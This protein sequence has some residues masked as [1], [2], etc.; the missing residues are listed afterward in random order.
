M[1]TPALRQSLVS[2]LPCTESYSHQII[3][4]NV[5]VDSMPSDRGTDIHHVM[6]RYADHCI[7][8][9]V[10]ADWAVF[11][12]LAAH[13][14]EEA[15]RILDGLRLNYVVDWAHIYATEITLGLDEYLQPAD[16]Y[17]LS[18]GEVVYLERIPGVTY[19]YL[20]AS[21]IG[22]L[23]IMRL[24]S[25]T[26]AAIDDAKSHPRP[27][28]PNTFQGRLYPYFVFAHFPKI[29]TV[30]FTLWFVRY[31]RSF[32]SITWRREQMPEMAAEIR[33]MRNVQLAIH[34]GNTEIKALP[35][36]HCHY[37]P[38]ATNFTCSLAETNPETQLSMEE[39]LRKQVW[40]DE[41]SQMNKAIL[42]HAVD[43]G[44]TPHYIDGKGVERRY[45][46]T[47]EVHTS[48]PLDDTTL[49]LLNEWGQSHRDDNPML[50]RLEISSTKLKDRLKAKKRAPLLAQFEESVIQQETRPKLKV[51]V[52]AVE[53]DAAAE[54]FDDD[55]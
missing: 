23:D 35:G 49:G 54:S 26:A 39:R 33:R 43:A 45:E 55:F 13:S 24:L 53:E 25:A 48:F 8:Q 2:I 14:G 22:T 19:S 30:E 6:S 11:D 40:L 4:G 46:V 15:G 17:V 21:Y 50:W 3:D 31:V 27:F 16:H 36:A 32:R 29:E 10:P 41:V 51:V 5:Q 37:C 1:Y 38:R 12:Q 28:E 20:P 44:Q 18:D 42:K 34:A 52:G 9:Q 7:A 47:E